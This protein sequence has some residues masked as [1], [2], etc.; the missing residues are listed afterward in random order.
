MRTCSN[1]ASID[2][3]I[4]S[5]V[6]AP[7]SKPAGAFTFLRSVSAQPLF[8]SLAFKEENFFLLPT[9][10]INAGREFIAADNAFRSLFPCVATTVTTNAP[11]IFGS[12]SSLAIS[13]AQPN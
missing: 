2:S 12:E 7:I 1:S 8:S 10:E 9:K 5:G 11:E 6:T 4:S 13:V 3:E